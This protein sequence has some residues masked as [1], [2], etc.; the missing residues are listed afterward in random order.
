MNL[1]DVSKLTEEQARETLERIRWPNGPVCAYCGAMD[2][3]TKFR[4]KAHRPGVYKCNDCGDQFTVTVNSVMEASHLPIRI[5]LMAFSIMCSSK[6]GVS[7]LQLQ[8]QLGLGSYRSAWHLAHRIRHAMQQEPLAGLLAG[9]VE[10]DECYVGGRPKRG[11]GRKHTG[12]GTLKTPIVA[13]VERGG[14][15]RARPLTKVNSKTL[16]GAI[17]EHVDPKATIYTDQ[18]GAYKGIGPEFA[19]GH[20]VVRHTAKEYVRGDVHTNTVE[21]FFGLLKRSVYGSWHH[22][23]KRHLAKYVDEVSFRWDYRKASDGDRTMAAIQRAEGKRLTY[24]EP[25]RQ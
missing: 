12:R 3:I 18:L 2:N 9:T 1:S 11:Q 7:A 25:V 13:L 14:R 17:R 19:G 16:K 22:V 6:K 5:W 10:V 8:R 24:R 15:V 23:S 4:G 20:H 21:A